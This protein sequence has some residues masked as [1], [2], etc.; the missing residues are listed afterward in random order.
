MASVLNKIQQFANSPKG[1]QMI[2]QLS[3]RAQ[4]MSRDP[5]T[6]AKIEDVRRRF[7]SGRAGSRPTGTTGTGTTGT[8]DTP[9]TGTTGAGTGTGTGTTY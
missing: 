9:G 2:R 7:Q 8:T 5:R 6:R 1:K 3:E 4:Q